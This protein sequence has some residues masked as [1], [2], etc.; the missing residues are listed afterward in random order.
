MYRRQWHH[1]H[2]SA[3]LFI[4]ARCL[5][6]QS[7]ACQPAIPISKPIKRKKKCSR[8][9]NAPTGSRGR[10]L[11]CDL[12]C[13]IV[14]RAWFARRCNVRKGATDFD[15]LREVTNLTNVVLGQASFSGVRRDKPH[16]A[17]ARHNARSRWQTQYHSPLQNPPPVLLFNKNV[18]LFLPPLFTPPSSSPSRH[19]S[20]ISQK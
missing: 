5:L 9:S 15:C 3:A 20:P 16:Y 11:M 4:E 2:E 6:R 1:L 19:L 7:T 14:T 12:V 13:T 8:P 17:P 18:L 10:V